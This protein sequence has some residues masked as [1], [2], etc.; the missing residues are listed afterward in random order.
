MNEKIRWITRA[1]VLIALLVVL[2]AVTMPLGYTLITGSVVNLI[3]IISVMTSGLPVGLSVAV[4]APVMSKLLG[5][6][7]LWSLIPFIAVGNIV[8]VLFWHIIGNRN[9]VNYYISHITALVAASVLK[10]C[11]LYFSIVRIAI[12][13]ILGLSE[14][15]AAVVSNMYSIPQLA[16][17]SIGGAIAILILPTLKKAIKKDGD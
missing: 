3:L 11:V 2:Q 13:L 15:Q 4:V 16:T 12:P 8:L 14:Q 17:A 1:A 10:F 9:I 7:P 5:I 6:G